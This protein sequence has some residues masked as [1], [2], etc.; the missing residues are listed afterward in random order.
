MKGIKSK[1]QFYVGILATILA[2]VCTVIALL[3]E[4]NVRFYVSGAI[5]VALAVVN[6]YYAFQ[7]KGVE[8]EILKYTDER[9]RY[10]AMKSCQ[11]MVQIVN[12]VL[13]G[14]CMMCLV[15]YGAFRLSAL[16]IVAG[17]L[18]GVLVLIFVTTLAVNTYFE[19]HS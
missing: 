10:I 2:A 15:L 6:F 19:R 7:K 11:T 1:R 16:V 5:L 9:D 12:Y 3:Q 14:V 17:T 8:E 13:L 4:G 18:C